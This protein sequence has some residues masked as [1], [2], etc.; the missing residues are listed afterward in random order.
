M[1][2]DDGGAGLQTG[3]RC[4]WRS[5][6]APQPD[7]DSPVQGGQVVGVDHLDQA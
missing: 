3:L 5:Q 7:A 1:W 4:D 6:R 2:L